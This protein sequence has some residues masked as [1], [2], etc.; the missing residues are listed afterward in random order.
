[1]A[2]AAGCALPVVTDAER[3]VADFLPIEA[4]PAI[5]RRALVS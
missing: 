3:A 2:S 1:M 5:A 4:D